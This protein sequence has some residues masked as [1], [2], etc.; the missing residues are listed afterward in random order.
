LSGTCAAADTTREPEDEPNKPRTITG[1]VTLGVGS[2]VSDA[3][4][5]EVGTP[6][7]VAVADA[8]AE[9]VAD[10]VAV[11]VAEALAVADEVDVDDA[12]AV[13]DAV[14]VDDDVD[15]SDNCGDGVT[16]ID[17]VD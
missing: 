13:A 5:V 15:E 11:D 1:G 7:D 8:V 3:M 10:A 14:L 16:A 17:E 9:D 2:D 12:L 6:D 4:I